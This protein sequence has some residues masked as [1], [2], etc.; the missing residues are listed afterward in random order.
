MVFEWSKHQEPLSGA[1]AYA[2][3]LKMD[4]FQGRLNISTA[5]TKQGSLPTTS[6]PRLGGPRDPRQRRNRR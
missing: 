6:I 2:I 4:E 1:G 5:L 3:F